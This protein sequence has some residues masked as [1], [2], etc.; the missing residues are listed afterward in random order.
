MD[1]FVLFNRWELLDWRNKKNKNSKS[2]NNVFFKLFLI[3]FC[4]KI[5]IVGKFFKD[6]ELYRCNN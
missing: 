3:Y 6:G 1:Y 4:L 5:L 2:E